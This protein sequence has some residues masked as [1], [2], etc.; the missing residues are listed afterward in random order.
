MYST[1]IT[2]KYSNGNTREFDGIYAAIVQ[3]L[4]AD[5][6]SFVNIEDKFLLT[7]S[8]W[9]VKGFYSWW[10]RSKT[11]L[12]VIQS[13]Y[14]KEY[15]K[16]VDMFKDYLY[17]PN[18]LGEFSSGSVISHGYLRAIY[19]E[20]RFYSYILG[21]EAS[22]NW[23]SESMKNYKLTRELF[24]DFAVS[25]ISYKSENVLPF[26]VQVDQAISLIHNLFTNIQAIEIQNPQKSGEYTIVSKIEESDLT[27]LVQQIELIK[28]EIDLQFA[29]NKLASSEIVEM[30]SKQIQTNLIEIKQL[31]LIMSLMDWKKWKRNEAP[32]KEMEKREAEKLLGIKKN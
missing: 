24:K 9:Y 12:D 19:Q 7:I 13:D 10:D 32:F 20:I 4:R 5:I 14:K 22:Q 17:V 8:N 15:G 30:S 16:L 2:A 25:T 11:K 1:K 6:L 27:N 26:Q 3:N 29:N 18:K 31:L 28:S 21:L 23:K